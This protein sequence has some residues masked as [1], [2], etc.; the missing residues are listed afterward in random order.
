M[1]SMMRLRKEVPRFEM[2]PKIFIYH[3]N[4]ISTVKVVPY[5]VMKTCGGSRCLTPLINLGTKQG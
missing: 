4:R 5:N 2:F 1:Q 3:L